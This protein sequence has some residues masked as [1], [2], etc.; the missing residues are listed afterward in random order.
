MDQREAWSREVNVDE[1]YTFPSLTETE[2]EHNQ[3]L[4]FQRT[5]G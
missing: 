1:G 5:R 2:E 3:F 4:P